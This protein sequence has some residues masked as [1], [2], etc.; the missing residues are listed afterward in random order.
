MHAYQRTVSTYQVRIH[1]YQEL[2]SV[3]G[4]NH[5][6]ENRKSEI[7][8]NTALLLNSIAALTLLKV[9]VVKYLINLL[10]N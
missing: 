4:F 10:I 7:Q 5:L 8:L 1:T 3:N 9:F 2:V 6:L